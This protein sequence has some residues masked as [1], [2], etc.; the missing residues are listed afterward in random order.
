MG[1]PLWPSLDFHT[2]DSTGGGNFVVLANPEIS[3]AEIL[4]HRLELTALSNG[5]FSVLPVKLT[6]ALQYNLGLFQG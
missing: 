3:S 1:T 2:I 6:G 5:I 4:L